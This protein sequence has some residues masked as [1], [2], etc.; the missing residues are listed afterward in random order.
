MFAYCNNAP[1]NNLDDDGCRAIP[2][3]VAR[4]IHNKVC[5][6][7][8]QQLLNMGHQARTELC[9]VKTYPDDTMKLGRLDVYDY[10]ENT[11]YEVKSVQASTTKRTERQLEK[12]NGAEP[13]IFSQGPISPG[14]Q[15][16]S[17]SFQYDI[18]DVTYYTTADGLVVY[19][20]VVNPQRLKQS[21]TSAVIAIGIG[22]LVFGGLGAFGGAPGG[23]VLLPV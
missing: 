5:E 2:L 1:T 22:A 3:A 9:V 15:T 17:G 10:T 8:L 14:T 7:I 16:L 12:Y 18:Y 4:L 21:I 19:D 11:Y 6:H 20:A 13:I 23:L